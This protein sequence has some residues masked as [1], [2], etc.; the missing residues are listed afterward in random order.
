M[1]LFIA[2]RFQTAAVAS[3]QT[4]GDR[5]RSS[6][7]RA[8][9]RDYSVV[10]TGVYVAHDLGYFTD[11]GLDVSIEHTPSSKYL[12]TELVKGTYQIAQAPIDN[13]F[14]ALSRSS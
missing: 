13:F 6:G 10:A 9:C 8:S 3:A 14:L 2:V 11:E 5:R 1:P 7:L 12:V 4:R